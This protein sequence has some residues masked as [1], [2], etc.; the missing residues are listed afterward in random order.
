V[1]HAP[2]SSTV[3]AAAIVDEYLRVLMIPDPDAARRFVGPELR[4]RFTGGRAIE[5][6]VRMR[7]VQPLAH[8]RLSNRGLTPMKPGSDPTRARGQTPVL[9]AWGLTPV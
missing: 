7:G 5:R 6:S 3:D 1:S 2:V 8:A 9:V 4:I